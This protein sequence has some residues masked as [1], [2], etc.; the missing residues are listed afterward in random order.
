[1]Y[2]AQGFIGSGGAAA[3]AT[4]ALAWPGP[5]IV[6]YSNHAF[7]FFFLSQHLIY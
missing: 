5:S 3:W 6:L 2:T 7:G 1:M 4:P